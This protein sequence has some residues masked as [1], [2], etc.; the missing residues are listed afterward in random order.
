MNHRDPMNPNKQ[1]PLLFSALIL[2]IVLACNALVPTPTMTPSPVPPTAIFTPTNQPLVIS[3]ISSEE[4]SDIPA[5]TID[6]EVPVIL[7]NSDPRALAFNDQMR[8]LVQDEVDAFKLSVSELIAEPTFAASSFAVQHNILFQSEKLASIQFDIVGYVSGAAH[9]YHYTI[10]VNYEFERRRPL[11]FDE[12][13]VLGS[14]YLEIISTYC[15]AQ[16]SQRDL[17]F[18]MFLEGATPTL[19]NYRNW[20][21]TSEGLIIKFDEYQVAPYAAGPQTVMVP[22]KELQTVMDPAGPLADITQ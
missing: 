17:G 3:T 19:E 8:A 20:N 2:F 6:T 7:E 5:Y 4:T 13:F 18:D 15:I 14:N 9:P 10:T 16:L 1:Y 21:I 11:S 12:L 22:Y